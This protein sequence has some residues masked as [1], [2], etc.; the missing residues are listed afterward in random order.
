MHKIA[1]LAL[2][3][4][5]KYITAPTRCSSSK[6]PSHGDESNQRKEESRFHFLKETYGRDLI[7]V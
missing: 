2:G 1:L 3:A 7:F 6:I 4:I 5:F